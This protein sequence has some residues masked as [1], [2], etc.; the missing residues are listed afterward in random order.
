MIQRQWAVYHCDTMPPPGSP[1]HFIQ[2][3][4]ISIPLKIPGFANSPGRCFA[5][6]PQV[7]FI[8]LLS[9]LPSGVYL[10]LDFYMRQPM[11]MVR[12]LRELFMSA[13]TDTLKL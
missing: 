5:G 10:G 9:L 4:G 2:L 12:I 7:L 1:L 6:L 8:S 13:N 11:L 3:G